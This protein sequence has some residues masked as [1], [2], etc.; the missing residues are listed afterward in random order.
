MVS[1]LEQKKVDLPRSERPF[2]R[3]P[4]SKARPGRC[5]R[6][7]PGDGADAD[8]RSWPRGR[9]SSPRI[10]PCWS[11][12]SRTSSAAMHWYLRPDE[13]GRKAIRIVADLH[14]AAGSRFM[15]IGSSPSTTIIATPM[16]GPILTALQNNIK[17]QKE[18]GLSDYRHRCDEIRRSVSGR[19][20]CKAAALTWFGRNFQGVTH[21]G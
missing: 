7:G 6:C 4:T 12:S 13:P 3:L 10:V 18:M 16:R 5:S 20:G 14:Q 19:R 17:T 8:S 9:P 1:V 21:G 11:I 2:D 15:P